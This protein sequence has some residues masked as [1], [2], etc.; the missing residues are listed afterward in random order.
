MKLLY[1]AGPYRGKNQFCVTANIER[2]RSVAHDVINHLAPVWHPVTPHLNTQYMDDLA[3]HE[4]FLTGTLELM[5]RCDAVLVQGEWESSEG[6]IAEIAEARRL[7][8]PVYFELEE[9]DKEKCK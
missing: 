9:I 5:R 8:M 2:A 4:Y 1:I 3:S 6:T 7:G